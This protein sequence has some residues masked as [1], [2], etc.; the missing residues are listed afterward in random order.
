MEGHYIFISLVKYCVLYVIGVIL[1]A[2]NIS[3]IKVQLNFM[4]S[5]E[6]IP[7]EVNLTLNSEI[8]SVDLHLKR[9]TN[10]KPDLPVYTLNVD[11][12]GKHVHQREVLDTSQKIGFYHDLTSGAVFQ[13]TNT[14]DVI[15]H[16]LK[17]L[18]KGHFRYGDQTY[19]VTHETRHK[20]ETTSTDGPLYNLE[21]LPDPEHRM[22]DYVKDIPG[23]LFS[24]KLTKFHTSVSRR[25][26][27][28]RTRSRRQTPT[29]HVDIVAVVDFKA[30]SQF[31]S[32]A[33]NKTLA[34]ND[35]RQYYSFIIAGVDLLYQ[36]ITSTHFIT[37]VHLIKVIVAETA[38]TSDFT[39][40][41][42]QDNK[43]DA[44]KS[45]NASSYYV[46][47]SE[48]VLPYDHVMVFTGFDLVRDGNSGTIG[49]AYL[50]T[51]CEQDGS[52]VSI[53]ED[54]GDYSCISTSAHELGHSF[55]MFHDGEKN[56]CSLTSRYIMAA[57]IVAPADAT[58]LN[59]WRFSTCS[60]DAMK[61]FI[62]TLMTK[63]EECLSVQ[64]TVS[65]DVPQVGSNLPGLNI[66]ANDQCKISYGNHS[67]VCHKTSDVDLTLTPSAICNYRACYQPLSKN[68]AVDYETL[69]G[70]VCSSGKL[71]KYGECVSDPSA[72]V[73][74]NERC[75][76]GD[77]LLTTV[78][79]MTCSEAVKTQPS[80]C[81][82]V[83]V[84]SAC[85]A[86]CASIY[87]S[88]PGCEYGDKTVCT[89]SLCA[90]YAQE[91]CQ[92]C[93]YSISTTTTTTTTATSRATS[94]QPVTSATT[95]TTSS[96]VKT[97]P[98]SRVLS[99]TSSAPPTSTTRSTPMDVGANSTMS[100][101]TKISFMESSSIRINYVAPSTSVN[102]PNSGL[103]TPCHIALTLVLYSVIIVVLTS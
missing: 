50:S 30:Y 15:N 92:T 81:Y 14:S 35:L 69:T 72:P 78:N 76:F 61:T 5:P 74:Q 41:F 45:L 54:L 43:I 88:Q 2:G 87:R 89:A 84:S 10:V 60:L 96:S 77:N 97:A 71:C 64:L 13:I 11:S 95:S 33:G 39:E 59:P 58:K 101:T 65:S 34:L 67:F 86:S 93:N 26:I 25:R 52:S 3:S 31:L 98:P 27:A 28:E 68:C 66:S 79:N 85:C 22:F 56:A 55:S 82:N 47:Q 103:S 1:C 100:S 24:K 53:I 8:F 38:E 44:D 42:K 12:T 7:S 75:L 49:L 70:T 83:N 94:T 18:F 23:H 19:F 9:Q 36:G 17:L 57:Y 21:V 4:Y 32:A 48:A 46:S 90:Q 20:R 102:S 99:S 51:M 6:V 62:S 37:R 40:R 29:Y 16:G 91:C 73:V 80:V 63:R